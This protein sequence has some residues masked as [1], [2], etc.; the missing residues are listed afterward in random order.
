MSSKSYLIKGN[1]RQFYCSHN[2]GNSKSFES[3]EPETTDQDQIYMRNTYFSEYLNDVISYA[4]RYHY[5]PWGLWTWIPYSKQSEKSK[6]T[7]TLL[8]SHLVINIDP[9][10]SYH[11]KTSLRGWSLWLQTCIWSCQVPKACVFLAIHSFPLSGMWYKWAKK[12]YHLCSELLLRCSCNIE[13]PSW[14]NSFVHSFSQSYYFY[15][16]LV[17]HLSPL[18]KRHRV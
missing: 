6:D 2:L 4:S 14:Y 11:T 1:K 3:W 18:W 8:E 15:F 12:Q 13:F 16:S 5:P 17:P 9:V 7:G 10:L